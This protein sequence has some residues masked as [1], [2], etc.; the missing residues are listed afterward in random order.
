LDDGVVVGW[1]TPRGM[2]G[3]IQGNDIVRL[4]AD[5]I[6]KNEVIV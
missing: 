6:I 5:S 2:S 1:Y 4:V 3:I